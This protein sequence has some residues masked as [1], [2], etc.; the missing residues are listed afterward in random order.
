MPGGSVN[1]LKGEARN[2]EGDKQRDRRQPLR[3]PFRTHFVSPLVENQVAAS[4]VDRLAASV[5]PWPGPQIPSK[6][7][8]PK[9]R[10]HVLLMRANDLGFRAEVANYFDSSS[11][12]LDRNTPQWLYCCLKPDD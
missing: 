11:K 9:A 6:R 3:S 2:P 1:Q 4:G 7:H 8:L 5:F 10:I 12:Y